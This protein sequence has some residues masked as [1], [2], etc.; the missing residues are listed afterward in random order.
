MVAVVASDGRLRRSTSIVDATTN[1]KRS[2]FQLWGQKAKNR[3]RQRSKRGIVDATLN[4]RRTLSEQKAKNRPNQR[5]KRDTSIANA[6]VNDRRSLFELWG[7]KAKN[8]PSQR[9]KRDTSIANAAVN[10]RRNL[11]EL[12]G[13]KAKN[14]PS[15]RS[16]VD[17]ETPVKSITRDRRYADDEYTDDEYDQDQREDIW[18]I[19]DEKLSKLVHV[20]HSFYF[21]GTD[22]VFVA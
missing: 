13:Q 7:Q 1:E 14:R 15:Q 17:Q 8:R 16:K 12:W 10:E 6:S 19:E 11:S 21:S 18:K 4:E 2:I 22:P 9:S 5:S 20:D 3:P